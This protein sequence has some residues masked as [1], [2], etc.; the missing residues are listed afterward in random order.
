MIHNHI[1]EF[2]IWKFK[3]MCIKI[4][5]KYHHLTY[6]IVYIVN[7][8]HE[9]SI[10]CWYLYDRDW[11]YLCGADTL[12]IEAGVMECTVLGALLYPVSGPLTSADLTLTTSFSFDLPLLKRIRSYSKSKFCFLYIYHSKLCQHESFE[13]KSR[14]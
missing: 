1:S 3:C 4:S 5:K 8:K 7:I 10:K 9:Y 6:Q 12:C 14:V 13:Y 2:E 11:W